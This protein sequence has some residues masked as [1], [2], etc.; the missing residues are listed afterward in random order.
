MARSQSAA[1][2][3]GRRYTVNQAGA[4]EPETN[5]DTI[6]LGRQPDEKTDTAEQKSAPTPKKS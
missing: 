4:P 1:T 2:P 3:A 5:E 6:T